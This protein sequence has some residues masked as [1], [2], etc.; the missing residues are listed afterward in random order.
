MEKMRIRR[1]TSVSHAFA[2]AG[3]S[4][5]DLATPCQT[6]DVFGAILRNHDFGKEAKSVS[7]L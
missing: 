7:R 6:I 4:G 2:H 1:Q 3:T 5:A